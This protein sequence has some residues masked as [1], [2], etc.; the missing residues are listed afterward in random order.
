MEQAGELNV[1]VD[2]DLEDNCEFLSFSRIEQPSAASSSWNR[3]FPDDDDS[4]KE[5]E[6]DQ[7]Y[8][9]H[10]FPAGGNNL[11]DQ[12]FEPLWPD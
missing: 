8:G 12:L 2:K 11:D 9:S 10:R 6:D 4:E 5:L 1:V 3:L 7:Q